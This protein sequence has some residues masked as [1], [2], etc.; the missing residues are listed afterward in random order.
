[1]PLLSITAQ[2]EQL[3]KAF[4]GVSGQDASYRTQEECMVPL[5]GFQ[6]P[7]NSQLGACTLSQQQQM[8]N[9]CALVTVL[10][11]HTC[12]G[13]PCKPFQTGCVMPGCLLG[14]LRSR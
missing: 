12:C 2:Q 11:G 8:H 13:L 10:Q 7:F 9:W 1:M 3:S 6:L 14:A 5:W 4:S